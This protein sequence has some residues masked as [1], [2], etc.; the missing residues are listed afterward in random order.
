MIDLATAEGRNWTLNHI[1]GVENLI[2]RES[3]DYWTVQV[4][5]QYAIPVSFILAV[6]WG[7]EKGW[8]LFILMS[9]CLMT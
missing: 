5:F 6:C 4:R 1:L 2:C 8:H 9:F 7:N 3:E